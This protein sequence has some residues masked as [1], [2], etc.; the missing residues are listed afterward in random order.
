[1]VT[2][3]S[4]RTRVVVLSMYSNEAFL[5]EALRNGAS[6]YVMKGA[7]AAEL[8][9]AIREAAAGRRY[10]SPPF[11]EKGIEAYLRKAKAAVSD[12]YDTL[13]GREREELHLEGGGR[14]RLQTRER[15][16]L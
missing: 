11:S 13:T 2:R 14:S 15:R 9:R 16:G 10:L 12:A 8:V 7:S 1:L 6:A 4:S 3:R 5:L